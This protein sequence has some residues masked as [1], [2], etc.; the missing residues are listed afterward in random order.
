M[1]SGWVRIP[2][3]I[4]NTTKASA[5]SERSEQYLFR[6]EAGQKGKRFGRRAADARERTERLCERVDVGLVD[7]SHLRK[8]VVKALGVAVESL[9]EH[10]G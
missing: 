4:Q 5:N 3:V 1:R 6:T 10:V 2:L 9:L 8:A 7:R